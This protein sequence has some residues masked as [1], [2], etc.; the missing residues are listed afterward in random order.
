MIALIVLQ[1][2]PHAMV[3]A[4]AAPTQGAALMNQLKDAGWEDP[5]LMFR[6]GHMATAG[7]LT[8]TGA[9]DPTADITITDTA[10]GIAYSAPITRDT[11][12]CAIAA[13][14]GSVGVL[15]GVDPT[16]DKP[17]VRNRLDQ[18]AEQG[19]LLAARGQI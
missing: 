19:K 2:R 3:T 16:M 13:K 18:L 14:A 7:R 1:Y 4:S 8:V 9:T 6:G 17:E 10:G 5:V 12:W 15:A 11:V